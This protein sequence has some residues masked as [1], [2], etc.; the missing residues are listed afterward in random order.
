M[1]D[2]EIIDAVLPDAYDVW[3]HTH[4]FRQTVGAVIGAL[5]RL[6]QTMD[7]KAQQGEPHG[8]ETHSR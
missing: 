4:D 3:T 2:D 5:R 8:K 7:R 1:T 6:K